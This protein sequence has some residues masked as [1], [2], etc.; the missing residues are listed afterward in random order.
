MV[1]GGRELKFFEDRILNCLEGEGVKIGF[2]LSFF[3]RAED[4]SITIV[5]SGLLKFCSHSLGRER[6]NRMC[7]IFWIVELS[8]NV[9][10]SV[11]PPAVNANLFVNCVFDIY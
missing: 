7:D 6:E 11:C 8:F 2:F 9:F 1:V 3:C 5:F 4:A 10:A